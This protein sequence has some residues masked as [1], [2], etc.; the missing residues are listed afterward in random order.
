MSYLSYI[1]IFCVVKINVDMDVGMLLIEMWDFCNGDTYVAIYK[2]MAHSRSHVK[3]KI[4]RNVRSMMFV[5]Y[6]TIFLLY[7]TA[8][9]ISHRVLLY[10]HYILLCSTFKIK[11]FYGVLTTFGN[12]S[13][14][15]NTVLL[16]LT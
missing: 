3:N 5:Q 16:Y 12:I 8:F 11:T 13:G 15:F 2:S 4:C 1:Y 14:I 7:F 6:F 10:S 9:I